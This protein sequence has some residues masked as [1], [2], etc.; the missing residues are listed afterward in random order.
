MTNCIHKIITIIIEIE[1]YEKWISAPLLSLSLHKT[2]CRVQSE[3]EK[4]SVESIIN[5]YV[6]IYRHYQFL[7]LALL[8][9]LCSA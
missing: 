4:P 2:I 3:E 7:H 5:N 1:D 6:D 9:E 8:M